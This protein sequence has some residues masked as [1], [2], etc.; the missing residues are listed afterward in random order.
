MPMN[1]RAYCESTVEV[2]LSLTAVARNAEKFEP[3]I[4]G[5][6]EIERMRAVPLLDQ[7]QRPLSETIKAIR[8][9]EQPAKEVCKNKLNKYS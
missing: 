5:I 6:Q 1:K 4:V 8:R 7:L 9:H 2:H 3:T